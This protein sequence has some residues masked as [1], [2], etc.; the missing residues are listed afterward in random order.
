MTG[1]SSISNA[2]VAFDPADMWCPVTVVILC[3]ATVLT[4]FLA[5]FIQNK[6]TNVFQSEVFP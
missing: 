1:H 2:A 5:E 6:L 3:R 4:V